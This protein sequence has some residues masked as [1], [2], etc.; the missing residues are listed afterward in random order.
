MGEH[1]ESIRYAYWS[2]RRVESVA[3]DEGIDLDSRWKTK[4][5]VF[6]L[7]WISTG[8]DLE[9]ENR[10]LR[11]TQKADRIERALGDLCVSD[12]VTPPQVKYARGTG[13]VE[14]SRFICNDPD[15]V[16]LNA[17]VHS[18][19]GSRA[20]VCLF[21]SRENVAGFVGATDRQAEGW[22]SSAMWSVSDWLATRCQT[23]NSQWDDAESISVEAM[24]IATTQ[25]INREFQANPDQPWTRGFTFADAADS[26]WFAEI[27]SDVILDRSRWAELDQP[28]D[29]ILIGA[30]LWIRTARSNLRRYRDFRAKSEAG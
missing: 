2:D 27:Y 22:T 9:R 4:I 19:D 30:P 13:L 11:R 5:T 7:P 25:G 24:K 15:R 10:N 18:S 12:F 8:F 17:R 14:F 16:V 26:E 3:E 21:G 20:I 29:R 1:G 28:V 23:N 6:R